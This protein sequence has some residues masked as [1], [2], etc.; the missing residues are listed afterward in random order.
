ME[1]SII[2]KLC[3][4][5]FLSKVSFEFLA[6]GQKAQKECADLLVYLRNYNAESIHHHKYN[7]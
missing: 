5:E 3:G 1:K 7:H 6:L 2:G 4:C